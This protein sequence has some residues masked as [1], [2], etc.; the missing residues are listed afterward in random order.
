[1]RADFCRYAFEAPGGVERRA[2]AFV[3]AAAVTDV[4]AFAFLLVAF[5]ECAKFIARLL[6][7]AGKN[8]P[9][10]VGSIL[11]AGNEP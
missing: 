6:V 3:H 10:Q 8:V 2:R 9:L 1:M 5:E 11:F 4:A 7:K